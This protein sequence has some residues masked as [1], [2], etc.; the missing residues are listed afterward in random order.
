VLGFCKVADNV[1]LTVAIVFSAILDLE[2]D[3]VC[4]PR[5]LDSLCA[6]GE[7]EDSEGNNNEGYVETTEHDD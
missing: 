2:G 3:L 5:A 6:L 1:E 7:E 4:D